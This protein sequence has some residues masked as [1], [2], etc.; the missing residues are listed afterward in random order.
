VI[1]MDEKPKFEHRKVKTVRNDP[2]D[3]GDLL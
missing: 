3:D 1:D 2:D